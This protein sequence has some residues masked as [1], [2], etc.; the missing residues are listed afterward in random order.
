MCE[1][2]LSCNTFKVDL[3]MDEEHN[4]LKED[5]NTYYVAEYVFALLRELVSFHQRFG[6]TNTST[7]AEDTQLDENP[8]DKDENGNSCED[9][10]SCYPFKEAIDTDEEH[11]LRQRDFA[12]FALQDNGNSGNRCE[13]RLSCNTFKVDLDM[14]EE[15]NPLKED[16]NTYCMTKY[17]FALQREYVSFHQRFGCTNTSTDAEDTQLDENPADKDEN[18]NSC[19]DNVTCYPFKEVMD[20]D[21][22]HIS[23]YPFKEAMDTDEEHISCYPLKEAMETDEEHILRQ[24]DFALQ[25][26]IC[27]FETYAKKNMFKK[28]QDETLSYED[29]KVWMKVMESVGVLNLPHGSATLFRTGSQYGFTAAHILTN[30]THIVD[31]DIRALLNLECSFVE[32]ESCKKFRLKEAVLINV[33]LDIAILKFHNN[34]I[35]ELPQPLLLSHEGNLTSYTDQVA[36]IGAGH[37][38]K[39]CTVLEHNVKVINPCNIPVYDINEFMEQHYEYFK[40]MCI[41]KG[42]GIESLDK[43][44]IGLTSPKNIIL[45]AFLG[46]GAS[47]APVLLKTNPVS[48]VGVYTSGYPQIFYDI[49][50]MQFPPQYTF[51]CATKMSFIFHEV[52]EYSKDLA[53]DIFGISS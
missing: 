14:D 44:Y 4:P 15:H 29:I 30:G 11:I 37:P 13:D 38:H 32:F 33:H 6:C 51:E 47:G 21:E 28:S 9:H 40:N 12:D 7:D 49:H 24:R 43:S 23:F 5:V 10:V 16:G 50:D 45:S 46:H 3:N 17:E 34:D 26:N 27:N 22:E 2:R 39:P 19:E 35:N 31:E 20:T 42:V 1:D 25:G 8:A 48:V 52:N 53:V 18:G 41:T 36:V